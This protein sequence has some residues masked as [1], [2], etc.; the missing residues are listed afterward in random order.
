M[1]D[2]WQTVMWRCNAASELKV[3]SLKRNL[4]PLGKDP[5]GEK[6]GVEEVNGEESKVWQ[7]L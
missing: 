1:T 6:E 3:K 2:I 4:D 5:V 7:S